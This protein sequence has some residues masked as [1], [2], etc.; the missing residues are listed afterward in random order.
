[1][2]SARRLFPTGFTWGAATAAYQIEGAPLDDG[3]GESI[4]DRFCR[5]GARVERGENGNVACD[6]YRRYRE[7]I[8]LMESLGIPAYRFSIAWPR[9]IPDGIGAVNERGLD[10]YERVVDALLAARIEPWVTLYHWDL[11][12]ALE[13][14]GGWPA[15]ATID[16]FG[17]YAD[18]VARRLGDRVKRWITINE[19]WVV[20]SCGYRWAQHAPG[21]R[22]ERDHFQAAFNLLVAHGEG[23]RAVKAAA[24]D[25]RVGIAHFSYRPRPVAPVDDE[26]L[27]DGVALNADIYLD[28][29]LLGEYPERAIR[30]LG[31]LAPNIGSRD[32]ERTRGTD[33]VG[34]QYYKDELVHP[35]LTHPMPRFE[36]FEYTDTGWPITPGGLRAHLGELHARY[37]LAEIVVTENGAAFPDVL[38]PEGR[39]H[40]DRRVAYLRA[41]IA[42]VHDA[43][44][45]GVPVTGYFVWSLL[46]NFEWTFGYR[47]RFGI[48]YT[49][50]ASQ[51]R[52][53]KDSGHYFA[54]VIREHG[55]E[56]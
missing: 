18:V 46:D 5:D 4:W 30:I 26:A 22:D 15:R 13:D 3:K 40:D 39:V 43:I 44:E 27:A 41:H 49:E 34:V 8:A 29:V 53:V 55:V 45:A 54:R 19:P 38:G 24:P 32:L 10:H 17:R 21:R 14:A 48:V 9:I 50:F 20:A 36:Q 25:A 1:M 12:Q 7:D 42:E 33:F 28:P 56:S 16:A 2:S 47:T 51:R 31:S 35:T 6:G 37:S 23:Y 52:W 11:P